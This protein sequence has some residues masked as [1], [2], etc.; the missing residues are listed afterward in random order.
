MVRG[1]KV[2]QVREPQLC[3]CTAILSEQFFVSFAGR[4]VIIEFV[5]YMSLPC[6][7]RFVLF[8]HSLMLAPHAVRN[9]AE[10]R[11]VWRDN[12]TEAI[13]VA[14]FAPLS[15]ILV[16]TAMT[17]TPVSYVAPTREISI[18]FAAIL[19]ARFLDEGQ[20]VRRLIAASCM[21]AGVMALALG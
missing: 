12:R 16:L 19:G 1:V 17:F 6:F 21:V 20:T 18:L 5:I 8:Y 9:W 11:L 2:G 15:Y 14:V 4:Q 3:D 13:G 7:K 10:V